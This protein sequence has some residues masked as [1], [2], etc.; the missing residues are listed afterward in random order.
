MELGPLDIS[1]FVLFI[2]SVIGIGIMKSR[3]DK[4]SED[5]F[6]LVGD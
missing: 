1:I 4:S 6:W 2:G 5:I 3:K